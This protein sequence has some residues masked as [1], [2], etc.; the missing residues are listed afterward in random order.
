[1]QGHKIEMKELKKSLPEKENMLEASFNKND[2][3]KSK[4]NTLELNVKKEEKP[5][6]NFIGCLRKANARI[7]RLEKEDPTPKGAPE[8]KIEGLNAKSDPIMV[9]LE[10][11]EMQSYDTAN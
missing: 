11:T 1:M 9:W 5:R 4:I 8:A 2:T 3:L 7:A 10:L 6:T